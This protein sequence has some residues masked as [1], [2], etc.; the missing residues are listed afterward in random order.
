MICFVIAL[1]GEAEPVIKNMEGV[2]S[3]PYCGMTVYRGKLCKKK[4]A[5]VVCGVGKVNAAAG[6]R[7]AIDTLKATAVINLG[8]A[9]GL[10]GGMS[11]G[12]LYEVKD[13]V[14]YDFDLAEINGTEI[15]RLN[16]FEE[17]FLPLS[18]LGL[19]PAKRLGTGDRFND[20]KNDYLFLTRTLKADLRDMEGCAIAQ[21]CLNSGVKVYSIKSVSDVAGSGSTPKQY[22]ENLKLCAENT[23]REIKIIF[24]KALNLW[25]R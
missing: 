1:K 14:Q 16:E 15:G 17:T 18:T 6:A 25:K 19:Y 11:A 24:E 4:T 21:V 9:G 7:Y 12:E 10:T 22:F 2:K 20:D 5:V 23:E 8:N 3:Y 13:T